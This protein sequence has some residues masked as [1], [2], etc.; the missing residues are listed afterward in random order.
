[1]GISKK[2]KFLYETIDR[3]WTNRPVAYCTHH[4]GCLTEKLMLVHKCKEKGCQ[5]LKEETFE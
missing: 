2:T 4:H 5:R 1:M 3:N